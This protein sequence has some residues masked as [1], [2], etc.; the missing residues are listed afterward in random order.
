MRLLL[1]TLLLIPLVSVAKDPLRSSA[2]VTVTVQVEFVVRPMSGEMTEKQI[3][4]S[5]HGSCY[6]NPD[7]ISE[8]L[9]E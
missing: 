4:E 7:E 1:L 9:C 2:S 8:I 5:S 3:E 6:V